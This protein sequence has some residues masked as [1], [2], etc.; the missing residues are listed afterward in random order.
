[1]V[2][3]VKAT[4]LSVA[5]IL[6]VALSCASEGP[7]SGVAYPEIF[8][9]PGF[10]EACAELPTCANPCF[11]PPGPMEE[12][13]RVEVV[14][15]EAGDISFGRIDTVDVPEG[16]G[17]PLGPRTGEYILAGYCQV[18]VAPSG[19]KTECSSAV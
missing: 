17:V 12:I 9:T 13:W 14:R 3:R 18:K 15:G 16:D 8:N 7:S 1:M 6:L 19:L 2:S 10:K 5:A 4:R 11:Q